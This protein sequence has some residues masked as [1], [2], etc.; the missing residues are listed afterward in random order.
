MDLLHLC[1]T[2]CCGF[3][4]NSIPHPEKSSYEVFIFFYSQLIWTSRCSI[5]ES[6]HHPEKNIKLW[7][8]E[9]VVNAYRLFDLTPEFLM[10]NEEIEC[11]CFI[12]SSFHIKTWHG[13]SCLR[14]VHHSTNDCILC[15]V[16]NVTQICQWKYHD[17]YGTCTYTCAYVHKLLF[18][19]RKWYL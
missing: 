14:V 8:I 16:T 19:T 18:C 5:E 1:K 11:T 6:W 13:H 3:T 7:G 9:Q 2:F 10:A 17:N 12:I 15:C 4:V